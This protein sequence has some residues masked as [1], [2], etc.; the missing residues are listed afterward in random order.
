MASAMCGYHHDGLDLAYR[1]AGH[2]SPVVLLHNGGM[3]HAIWRDVVPRLATRHEVFALDLLGYG[4]SARPERGYTLA[5]YTELLGAFLDALG[6]APAALVGNCMG[7]AIALSLAQQRPRDVSSLV[8]INPLTEATFRAGALGLALALRP[9]LPAGLLGRFGVPRLARRRLVRLQ[10]GAAGRAA[11]LDADE[12][13]C[14]CYAGPRTMR[15]L[16]GVLEDLGSYRALDELA[17]GP[18]FPPITTIWG[19]DNRVLSPAAGRALARTL[20]PVRE[21][22]LGGCGHLPMLEDPER[23]AAIITEAI[24]PPAAAKRSASR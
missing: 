18:A 10:L 15:P 19:L 4:A 21:E 1:R 6:V 20:R 23:V 14:G 11:G 7:S 17:P 16:L 22:W 3:S 2:G 13:L 8:L 12:E 9:A 24:A 5:R